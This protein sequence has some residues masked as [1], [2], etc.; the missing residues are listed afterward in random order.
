MPATSAGLLVFRLG[1]RGVEVFLVHPGGPYWIRKDS[2]AWSI[3]KGEIRPNEDPL[4]AARREFLEETGN[5]ADGSALP[6]GVVR[7][8]GRKL[9][10]AW[11]VRGDLDPAQ[12]RSNTFDLEWPPRS[13]VMR[14]FPE[15]DRAAWFTIDEAHQ[16]ILPSQAP[17]LDRLLDALSESS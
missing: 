11:A 15:V 7:Q 2:G 16:R 9:V 12:V 8:A 4:I 5:V 10:H 3:P 17:L 1:A 6:L 14:A 13:G